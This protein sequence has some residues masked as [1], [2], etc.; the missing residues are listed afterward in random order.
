LSRAVVTI[1]YEV[2]NIEIALV[3]EERERRGKGA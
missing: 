3:E 2:R 1:E